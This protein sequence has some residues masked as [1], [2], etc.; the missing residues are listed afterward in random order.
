MH[1]VDPRGGRL[2]GA[3]PAALAAYEEALTDF[4]AW[5]SVAEGL[6]A[7]S[8]DDVPG[9]VMA[10]VLHAYQM[11]GGRDPGRIRAAVP[12][13]EAAAALPANEQE[14]WHL[15][16]IGCV[17]ADDYAGAGAAL[18]QALCAQPRDLLAL[19]MA[20]S[21]DYLAGE[22]ARLRRRI[23][24]VLPAW[25]SD[26]PGYHSVQAMLAFGLVECGEPERA[27]DA[28]HAALALDAG[29]ARAHHAM[30][31]V[32]ETTERAEAG[33]RWLRERERAWSEGTV[34]ATH[35][36]WHLALFHLARG[37][38]Q[39][40]LALYDRHVRAGRSG[41]VAD[42]IDASALLWR[43]RLDGI[44]A[45][46]RWVELAAAWAPRVDDAYCSFSDVHAMLAFVGAGDE[47]HARQL[48]Q[49]LMRSESL[50]TRYGE[51]TRQLGLP[52]CR[53]L[54]A[55]GHGELAHAIGLFAGLP[56]RVHRLGGSHAQR[57]VLHLTVMRAVDTI[58]RPLRR[59]QHRK[60]LGVLG[61]IVAPSLLPRL[62][63]L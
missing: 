58:R 25:P 48:E 59:T 8:I 1:L 42:L 28:A 14:R 7:R 26:L 30:A 40:A 53:G 23:E 5:R 47:P 39:L 50:P 10:R 3:T 44:D 46:A 6:L 22:T 57:D 35:L 51:S 21:F 55:F 36:W 49:A 13:I 29:D 2:S 20:S 56:G 27:E 33:A 45:G 32:F 18:D 61:D 19:A 60:R 43:L 52:A 34:V 62:T 16:A 12:G 41:E 63:G 37:E 4:V 15:A 31:H 38:G 54:V 17:L 9:F 11:V 24:A